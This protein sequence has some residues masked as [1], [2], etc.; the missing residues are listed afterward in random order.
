MKVDAEDA[1][2]KEPPAPILTPGEFDAR[3]RG[4]VKIAWIE[5]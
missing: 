1:L 5:V 2:V 3:T 4:T